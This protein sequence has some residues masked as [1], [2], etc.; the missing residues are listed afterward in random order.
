MM[1]PSSVGRACHVNVWKGS[2]R[3]IG[4]EPAIYAVMVGRA[5]HICVY[6]W[7]GAGRLVFVQAFLRQALQFARLCSLPSC[8]GASSWAVFRLCWLGTIYQTL[9][10]LADIL[11]RTLTHILGG[12]F[13]RA[14]QCGLLPTLNRLR[15]VLPVSNR[16]GRVR[17][18]CALPRPFGLDTAFAGP[19]DYGSIC[20][21]R[22]LLTLHCPPVVRW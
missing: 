3:R 4:G 20:L 21:P 14:I 16:F 19:S 7:R 17:F 15:L 5:C 8:R 18:V 11:P 2:W 9:V 1:E 10:A 13:S 6:V 12:P 22:P